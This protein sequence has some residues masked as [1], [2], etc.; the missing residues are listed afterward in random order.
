MNGNL[1]LWDVEAVGIS[2]FD[3][4][5]RDLPEKKTWLWLDVYDKD[6]FL[7]EWLVGGVG[8][9]E[10]NPLHIVQKKQL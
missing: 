5:N 8:E 10:L 3:P 1:E 7:G 6:I 2:R 4:L 9:A